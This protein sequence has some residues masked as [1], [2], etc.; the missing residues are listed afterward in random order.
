MTTSNK[1]SHL[2]EYLELKEYETTALEHL[3]SIGRTTAP[4]LAEAT[5]IPKARIYSVLESLAN[6][7]YIKIIPGRPKEYQPKPPAKI[8][9]RAVENHRQEYKSYRQEIESIRGDFIDQFEP[10]YKQASDEVTPTEELFYVVDVG[11]S[12]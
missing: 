9:D 3:L 11:D 6:Q 10:L 4:N 12:S 8:L 7:G 2:L 1:D 5:E